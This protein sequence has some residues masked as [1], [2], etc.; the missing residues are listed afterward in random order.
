MT[1]PLHNEYPPQSIEARD[2]RHLLHPATHLAALKQT[3]PAV[4]V[5]AK[6]VYLWDS[7]GNQ[8]LEAMGGL[9]CATLGYGV[10]ELAE[11]AHAQLKKLAYS[12][13]F[14]G[15]TNEP[16]VLLAEK[17]KQLL[18]MASGK[19]FF[20]LSG[21]DANDTQIKL[22]RAYNNIRGEPHRKT[23]ISRWG[24]YHGSTIGSGS[25]TG[26][27]AFH[28]SFDLPIDGVL[29]ADSPHFYRNCEPGETEDQFVQRVASN[30]DRMIGEAGPEN[31]AA[32][33]VEPVQ[34]AGGVV[35]PPDGYFTAVDAVLR[36]H[37]IPMIDDE[38]ICGFGRT[39]NPFG[40]QTMGFHPATF[41]LA[42]GLS[43]AYLPISAVL[44]PDWM[45]D[46]LVEDSAS[47]GPFS[48]GFTYSGHPVSAAV[49][50]RS[51]E[52]MEERDLFAHAAEMAVP[53]QQH[54][55]SFEDHPLVGEAL[56]IGMIG[57]LELVADK[58]T[59]QRFDPRQ[60]VGLDC[61]NRC[62]DHGLIVRALGDTICFCPPL[63]ITLDQIDELF[64]K[65]RKALDET[66]ESRSG[67]VPT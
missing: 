9:W 55:R 57:A 14:G 12:Q 32:F 66:L 30:L 42:K 37:S 35:V 62:L 6:G 60:G 39:G 28:R 17:L 34:G 46:A 59:K 24:G 56:G 33:I 16:S 21:S 40:Y 49:A 22:F 53:F 4:H 38:V 15:K 18:P 20:G 19:V 65:F 23:I 13:L 47:H 11:T 36:K 2:L 64:T 51:I 7:K 1:N 43:S 48:H 5:K 54:L 10:D 44:V 27:P 67:W 58:E 25:L 61:M 52:L 26:L 45:Y 50:L 41:S 8:H 3:G 31:I 29:H 63:I